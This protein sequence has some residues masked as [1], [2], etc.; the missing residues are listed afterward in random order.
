MIVIDPAKAAGQSFAER[1]Q[2][3]VRQMHGVGLKRLPGDRRHHQR[4]KSSAGGIQLDAD[5]L[6]NL[7]ELAGD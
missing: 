5:T 3:L 2:E 1:S 6:A 4:A 7:R